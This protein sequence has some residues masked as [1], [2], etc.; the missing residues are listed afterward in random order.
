M[1][2]VKL[3]FLS[4]VTNPTSKFPHSRWSDCWAAQQTKRRFVSCFFWLPVAVR[5]LRAL[6]K[7]LALF[8]EKLKSFIW[9]SRGTIGLLLRKKHQ[10]CYQNLIWSK[11]KLDFIF[12]KRLIWYSGINAIFKLAQIYIHQEHSWVQCLAQGH[13]GTWAH[14]VRVGTELAIF[15]TG[16]LYLCTMTD[17]EKEM[18]RKFNTFDFINCN[19]VQLF[20]IQFSGLPLNN[21]LCERPISDLQKPLVH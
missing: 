13:F 9:N 4:M 21:C 11:F 18:G 8:I 7:T 15:Q 6:K 10:K 3:Y 2:A 14:R 1:F 19:L 16:P 20:G 5:L 17:L 12:H